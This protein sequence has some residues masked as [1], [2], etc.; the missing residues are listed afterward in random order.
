MEVS[1]WRGGFFER[2]GGCV[3]ENRLGLVG[4]CS[5]EGNEALEQGRDS[6]IEIVFN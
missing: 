4:G 3:I 1:A 5:S 6:A 2:S